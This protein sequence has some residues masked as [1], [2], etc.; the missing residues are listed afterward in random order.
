MGQSYDCPSASE[1]TLKDM[2]KV[3]RYQSH[4]KIQHSSMNRASM[5]CIL[6]KRKDILVDCCDITGVIEVSGATNA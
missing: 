1:V 5:Q 2:G 3:D 6:L 4:N